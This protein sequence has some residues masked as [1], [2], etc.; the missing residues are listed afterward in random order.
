LCSVC[1]DADGNRF[2]IT[3]HV[4]RRHNE[5]LLG[6]IDDV[7]RQAGFDRAGLHGLAF[8]CGPGSFTGVRIAAACVQALALAH[9]LPVVPVG[10]ADALVEAAVRSGRIAADGLLLTSIRS[11]ARHYYLSGYSHQQGKISCIESVQL[12]D[13]A[14]VLPETLKEPVYCIGARPDWWQTGAWLDIDA[15]AADILDI[16][17]PALAQNQGVS[18]AN[19]LPMYVRGD[20]PWQRRSRA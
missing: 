13:S 5:L 6:M 3:H 11:R 7:L 16:A 15:T 20:T 14:A 1:L 18:S 8:G 4:D 10:S 19:A 12:Y 17:I 2:E 9:D